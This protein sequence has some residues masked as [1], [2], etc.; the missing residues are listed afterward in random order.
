MKRLKTSPLTAV[1]SPVSFEDID[2]AIAKSDAAAW[3]N[4]LDHDEGTF[5]RRRHNGNLLLL[6]KALVSGSSDTVPANLFGT[7][8]VAGDSPQAS[9]LRGKLMGKIVKQAK[10]DRAAAHAAVKDLAAV[11]ARESDLLLRGGVVASYHAAT[12]ATNALTLAC[13]TY[14][15]RVEHVQQPKP[16]RRVALLSSTSPS[17]HLAVTLAAV[18]AAMGEVARR[19][20]LALEG[21]AGGKRDLVAK[22]I[23]GALQGTTCIE[24]TLEEVAGRLHGWPPAR[25][26]AEAQVERHPRAP[27]LPP[28]S[29]FAESTPDA[30]PPA[31]FEIPF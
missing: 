4:A 19:D 31:S 14:R 18:S 11:L 22:A 7:D 25:L 16:S 24:A 8:G 26:R 1:K 21:V 29:S 17:P 3:I 15:S 13:D 2:S 6:V 27:A 9:A 28:V 30:V 20:A 23:L 10:A 12:T 5:A